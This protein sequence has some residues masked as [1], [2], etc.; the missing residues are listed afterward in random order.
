[1]CDSV[2]KGMGGRFAGFAG[3]AGQSGRLQGAGLGVCWQMARTRS[4]AVRS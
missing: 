3:R 4:N 2:H 1:L